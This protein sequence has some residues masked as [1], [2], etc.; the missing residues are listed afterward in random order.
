MAHA[1]Q[2]YAAHCEVD[3]RPPQLLDSF[4]P[5]S[6]PRYIVFHS[7]ER[8]TPP[9]CYNYWDLVLEA[10]KPHLLDRGFNIVQLQHGEEIDTFSKFTDKHLA[11]I[12]FQ[13]SAHIINNSSGYLGTSDV[14][15]HMASASNKK[16]VALFG[17]SYP[18]AEGPCWNK[19]HRCLSPDF[20]ETKP[21]FGR[22]QNTKRINDIKPER[23][24]T[25]FLSLLLQEEAAI[26][27]SSVFIGDNYHNENVE[28]IPNFF[29]PTILKPNQPIN[30]RGDLHFDAQAISSWLQGRKA[31]LFIKPDNSTDFSLLSAFKPNINRLN[32][33]IDGNTT[34]E[35]VKS[36]K[37][38]GVPIALFCK[39]EAQLEQVR[40]KFIDWIVDL[41]SLKEKKDLD[42]INEIDYT[43]S[44]FRSSKTVLSDNQAY[45]T[46]YHSTNKDKDT[47]KLFDD[48]LFWNDLDHLY[49]F[50]TTDA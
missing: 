13:Q 42:N 2:A 39:E 25:E 27:L 7:A 1:T 16:I 40:L 29:N 50:N 49:I 28:I 34:L 46:L 11:N 23:I 48:P 44:K 4:Y 5:I 9:E 3:S 43:T 21:F 33:F 22:Y 32:V 41:F 17:D 8:N 14:F 31:N 35:A 20:S 18:E 47:S 12:G 36:I 45:P 10:L 38:S 19:D 6:F 37:R 15:M 30:I 24:A 26:G